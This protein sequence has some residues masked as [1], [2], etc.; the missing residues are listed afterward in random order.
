M[1]LNDVR[2]GFT[3]VSL[4][5]FIGIMVWTWA[6]QRQSAFEEAARLP[7]QDNDTLEKAGEGQ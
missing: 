7:F 5:L 4:V 1:D 2:T 6:R 3:V